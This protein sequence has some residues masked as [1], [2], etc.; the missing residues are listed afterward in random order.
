VRKESVVY[1]ELAI[2]MLGRSDGYVLLEASTSLIVV[3]HL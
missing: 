1:G 2:C 3:K